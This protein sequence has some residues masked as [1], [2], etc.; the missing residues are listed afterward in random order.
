M[1]ACALADTL[2]MGTVVVP[3]YAGVLS[4]LG[5]VVADTVRD[6]SRT[7][8]ALVPTDLAAFESL[9][10]PLER[11]VRD[12]LAT[13]GFVAGKVLVE[14]GLDMRYAGQA[15]ELTVP[16]TA[17]PRAAFDRLHEQR[18]GYAD[19]RRPVEVVTAR[20]RGVGPCEPVAWPT[21]AAVGHPPRPQLTRP[22]WFDG[23]WVDTPV[24]E[25]ATLGPGHELAGPAIVAGPE[26]T[27]VVA[28]GWRLGVDEVGTL[29]L[30]R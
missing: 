9:F 4:A 20:V 3:R 11:Q 12:D 24:F 23:A 19:E 21:L 30:S 26:A 15:Y 17:D 1:H 7:V 29:V 16:W 2:E 8:L 27:T 6:V 5:M 22:A 25:Q 18:Y 10:E 28:P 13:E 14:R